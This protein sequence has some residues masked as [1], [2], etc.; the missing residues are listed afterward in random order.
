MSRKTNKMLIGSTLAIVL[1][2]FTLQSMAAQTAP[3]MSLKP[4]QKVEQNQKM[5]KQC[6]HKKRCKHKRNMRHRMPIM[7]TWHKAMKGNKHFTAD[8]AKVLT[9]AA[10]LLYGNKDM[11]IKSITPV[12]S[13]R[14]KQFYRIEISSKNKPGVKTIM[15][16]GA[17]GKMWS[18]NPHNKM[19]KIKQ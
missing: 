19:M 16:N 3:A 5:Y 12:T 11:Q 1:S 8:D 2:V 4:A 13:K 14:G 6:P 18:K 17:N 15:M 7:F 10:I 9:Q